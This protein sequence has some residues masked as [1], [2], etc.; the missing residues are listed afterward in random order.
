MKNKLVLSMPSEAG[1][2]N[3]GLGVK[4]Y[5]DRKHAGVF[6]D[7]LEN[8]IGITEWRSGAKVYGV[9]KDGTMDGLGL[10]ITRTKL[11]YYGQ[12]KDFK[13]VSNKHWFNGNN[14]PVSLTLEESI[15]VFAREIDA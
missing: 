2:F 3:D 5:S 1:N 6:K 15:E 12:I 10:F 9:F 11:K 7:K 13:P 8:G 14:K 4:Y